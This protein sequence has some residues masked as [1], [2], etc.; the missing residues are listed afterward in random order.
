MKTAF[1]AITL[2][3]F[4][5]TLAA[6]SFQRL[7]ESDTYDFTFHTACPFRIATNVES[8]PNIYSFYFPEGAANVESYQLTLVNKNR[9]KASDLIST[10]PK[11]Q[12]GS[13]EG[14]VGNIDTECKSANGGEFYFLVSGGSWAL[15]YTWAFVLR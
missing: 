3:L 11:Y 6:P 10:S 7:I 2:S 8:C 4:G 12:C 13:Y 1:A 5:T 14:D 9:Q 15:N